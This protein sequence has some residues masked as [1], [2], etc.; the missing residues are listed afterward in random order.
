[1]I[2]LFKEEIEIKEIPQ[3]LLNRE[4]IKI[5]YGSVWN[6][7]ESCRSSQSKSFAPVAESNRVDQPLLSEPDGH[8]ISSTRVLLQE[9]ASIVGPSGC[10]LSRF[11]PK[12]E[13]PQAPEPQIQTPEIKNSDLEGS[14][15]N[16]SIPQEEKNISTMELDGKDHTSKGPVMEIIRNQP[17]IKHMTTY[18]PYMERE[19][20]II[21]PSTDPDLVEPDIYADPNADCDQ[22]YDEDPNNSLLRKVLQSFCTKSLEMNGQT[23]EELSNWIPTCISNC[24]RLVFMV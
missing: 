1:V 13:I 17:S 22:R 9:P 15:G 6:I 2:Q 16:I 3:I 7:V 24:R 14:K 4:N 11:I 23:M 8:L 20:D 10:P 18:D 19:I 12:E 21:D 5:S